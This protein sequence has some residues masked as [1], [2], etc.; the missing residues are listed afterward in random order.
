MG[1]ADSIYQSSIEQKSD[2]PLLD[3]LVKKAVENSVKRRRDEFDMSQLHL[4]GDE[5]FQGHKVVEETS[6]NVYLLSG[7]S[8]K[9]PEPVLILFWPR[10]KERLPRLNLDYI[11]ISDNLFWDKENGK[12]INKEEIYEKFGMASE[13]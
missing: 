10:L 12:V 2:R 8:D 9:I 3:K 7:Y 11:Q 4:R 5:I 6:R 1:I 13:N